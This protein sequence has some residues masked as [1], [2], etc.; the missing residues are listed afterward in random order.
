MTSIKSINTNYKKPIITTKNTGYAATGALILTATT[1]YCKNKTLR[2]SH[3]IL[4]IISALLTLLHIG[5]VEY[6]HHKCKKL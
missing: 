2:K 4:G 5:T 6:L 1:A 3:K